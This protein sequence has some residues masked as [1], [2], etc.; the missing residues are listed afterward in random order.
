MKIAITSTGKDLDSQV[1]PRFGRCAY[2]LIVNIDD[3]SFE[4]IDNASMSLGG[5]A[6]VFR[7]VNL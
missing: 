2:F 1:D 3:M 5:G 7:Q 4:A 6:E